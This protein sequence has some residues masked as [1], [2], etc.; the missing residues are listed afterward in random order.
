MSAIHVINL[1]TCRHIF[2]LCNYEFN[3]T[4]RGASDTGC[5]PD[6]PQIQ[7]IMLNIIQYSK[8]LSKVGIVKQTDKQRRSHLDSFSQ[9]SLTHLPGWFKCPGG[10]GMQ[11]PGAVL[12]CLSALPLPRGEKF[13]DTP[14]PAVE[15][16]LYKRFSSSN[17]P[18]F[19]LW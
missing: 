10:L 5:P 13:P 12:Y 11:V 6:S 17:P 19:Y 1:K 15:E 4:K 7:T 14:L 18:L 2:S 9:G 16:N 8:P 3:K